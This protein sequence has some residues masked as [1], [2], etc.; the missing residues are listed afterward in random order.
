MDFF[1]KNIPPH[2]HPP[3]SLRQNAVISSLL[4]KSY[5]LLEAA[6]SSPPFLT[7]YQDVSGYAP[8]S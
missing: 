3:L 1:T 6:G 2:Q 5:L 7:N 4:I 8:R